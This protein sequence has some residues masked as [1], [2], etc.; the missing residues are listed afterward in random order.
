[1]H[2]TNH[3]LNHLS[4]YER[5]SGYYAMDRKSFRKYTYTLS[6]DEGRSHLNY[7]DMLVVA[8]IWKCSADRFLAMQ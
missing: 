4:I 6:R 3:Q 1:M 7:R 8:S 5:D 2:I